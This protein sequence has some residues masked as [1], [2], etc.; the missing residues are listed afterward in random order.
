MFWEIC[1]STA[2]LP[3][4]AHIRLKKPYSSL[5]VFSLKKAVLKNTGFSTNRVKFKNSEFYDFDCFKND[6]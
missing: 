1:L 4:W 5:W 3:F 2:P 6:L